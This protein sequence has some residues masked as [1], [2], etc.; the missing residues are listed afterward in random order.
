MDFFHD[1]F[2]TDEISQYKIKPGNWYSEI[3]SLEVA[4][5]YISFKIKQPITN[6]LK[7]SSC[8]AFQNKEAILK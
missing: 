7:H 3:F 5:F 1:E 2:I 6:N 8:N 4:I